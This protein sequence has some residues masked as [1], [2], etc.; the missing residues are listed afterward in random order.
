VQDDISLLQGTWNITSL[1]VEGNTI[2]AGMLNGARIVVTGDQFTTFAMGAEYSG[3]VSIDTAKSPATF[4]LNFTSG[5]EKGNTS[6]GIYQLEGDDWKICLTL[7][8]K[9]RPT[10]FAT[11]AG[12]GH[13]LETL[14]RLSVSAAS[15]SPA[16]APGSTSSSAPA[17]FVPVPEL[18]GEWAMVSCVIDGKPL[19]KSMVKVG[20]RLGNGAETSV[21]F[22]NQLFL[23]ANIVV[24]K[25][26]SPSTIDY[27]HTHGA[28]AG[29]MQLGIYKLE[30]KTATFCFAAPG[31]PRP[32]EFVSVS[33]DGRTLSVWNLNS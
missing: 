26:A 28:N 29:Q 15:P 6:Y 4:D 14:K 12:S 10:E 21:W 22:G 1:E 13:A 5:P 3:K 20:K 19:D 23:R 9:V 17:N 33:G 32:N 2:P 16:S 31:Q 30:G 8:G 27:H 18:Q 11:K 25:A 24:N 7:R